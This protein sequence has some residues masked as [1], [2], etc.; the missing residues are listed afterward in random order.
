MDF[1]KLNASCEQ[2]IVVFGTHLQINAPMTNTDH[3]LESWNPH[4]LKLYN[5]HNYKRILEP[6]CPFALLSHFYREL[7]F[8]KLFFWSLSFNLGSSQKSSLC[9][10]SQKAKIG[11]LGIGVWFNLSW[12]WHVKCLAH[13]PICYF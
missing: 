5:L 6:Y 12:R 7:G 1:L 8:L 3:I 11:C 2:L 13:A 9:S 10:E 4:E